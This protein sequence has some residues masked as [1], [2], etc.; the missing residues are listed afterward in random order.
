MLAAYNQDY[1]RKKATFHEK[2]DLLI[3]GVP[4]R[5]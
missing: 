2:S 3:F 1:Q 4:Y 5:I